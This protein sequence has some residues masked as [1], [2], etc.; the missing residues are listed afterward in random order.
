VAAAC[1]DPEIPRWT[2]MQEGLTVE[3]AAA[4]IER[5]HDR[6]SGGLMARFAVVGA[7]DDL[8]VGQ[9]GVAIDWE[10]RSGE[11][12]YWV[13]AAARG[14]GVATTALCL[15][16]TWAFRSLGLARLELFADPHNTASQR[17]AERAGYVREGILRSHQPFKDRRMDSVV[18]SRLPSDPGGTCGQ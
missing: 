7:D 15:V 4:W 2:F 1:Q 11:T 14:R 9:A 18:F 16:S 6:R 10:R 5:S 13:A 17:V 12:F 3:D 8:L